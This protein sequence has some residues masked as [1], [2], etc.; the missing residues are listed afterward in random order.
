[1][2]IRVYVQRIEYLSIIVI[3]SVILNNTLVKVIK[4]YYKTLLYM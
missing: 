2:A 3:L 1:M 4:L